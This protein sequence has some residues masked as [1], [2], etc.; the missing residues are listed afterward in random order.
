VNTFTPSI[1]WSH[2]LVHS[3]VWVMQTFVI[4]AV[5]VL[6]VLVLIGRFTEWGRQ[7]WRV[8]GRYFTGRHSV[9]VWAL[10]AVLLVSSILSVRISV[11]LSYQVNDLFT[12]L[13]VAFQGDASANAGRQGFWSTMGV[14][15]VLA[16]C[17]VVRL[18]GD[19]YVTQRFQI[20]W[21]IWLSRRF[22]DDW[23]TDFAYFRGQFS[24]QP[25][26]N[27]DQRIQQD[28]DIFTAGVGGQPNNPANHSGDTLLFGAVEAVLSVFSF[29][30]I[31]WRLSGPLTLAG[32]TIPKALFWIV[33]AYVFVV[34]VIA[35]VIGRPLIR[36]SFVN[37]LRNAGFRYALVRVRDGAAAIGLYRGENVERAVLTRRLSSVMDNYRHWLNRV[38]LFTGWNLSVGQAIN[39]LPWLVQAQRLFARQVSFG[40]V[41]QSATAFGAI[42]DSLSFFRNAY[43]QFASYRAAII[44]LDG[45]I[46]ENSRAGAYT[47]VATA[48]SADGGLEADGVEVRT[49]DG[50][51][52]VRKLDFS[53][54]PGE[55]L[56]ISGPSGIGK[57]VLLQ[58]LAGL[59]PFVTGRV[60]LPSSR[61]DAMFVPQLPYLPLGDLRAALSYPLAQ[62]E[63]TD[64]Q[65]QRAMAQVALSHLIIRLNEAPYWAKVLS[66]GEQQRIAFARIL[67]SRPGAVFLD[68]ST[69][70]MDEGMELMLYELIRAELPNTIVVSV[71]HRST[72]QHLHA[73]HLEL[74]G[75]GEWRLDALPTRS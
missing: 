49:P 25:I 31:L 27:P 12:A 10:L 55:T 32:I 23:L 36:L 7:F 57:T 61:H 38:V 40:D 39:P 42:H 58:S 8:S 4:A 33:I 74:V 59:W 6:A 28:I 67:L 53:L 29:G 34:T 3:A 14:F 63:L 71:S 41:W 54:A 15:A 18:L 47:T 1:D 44:R 73:R 51:A 11:L 70:A 2:E 35:F 45:L 20:R 52:L 24:R 64:R 21:R 17:Y 9:P 30:A 69:S 62:G 68:E 26:D 66:V 48:T 56:L 13:Q 65:I 19:L 60:R 43:D 50:E 75:G 22:I 72:L 37:E 5:C 46:D 16:T